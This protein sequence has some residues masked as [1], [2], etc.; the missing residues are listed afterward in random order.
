M[1]KQLAAFEGDYWDVDNHSTRK[2]HIVNDTLRYSRGPNNESA[3]VPLTKN[4]FKM[5]SPVEVLVSFDKKA[6]PKTMNV[7]VGDDTF[8]L[9]AFDGNASWTKDLEIFKGNY[10]AAALDT[11]YSL[12]VD[13]EKLVLTH[14]RLEP[15][16]LD[17][18]I[19]VIKDIFHPFHLKGTL[20]VLSKGFI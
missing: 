20:T 13:Q 1:K 12:I 3:L 8:N 16:Q 19:P 9:V 18:R 15:V 10:Y 14:P 7:I 4:S 17:P 11:S 5:I 2:I 6:V